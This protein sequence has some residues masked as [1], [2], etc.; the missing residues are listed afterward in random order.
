MNL[1]RLKEKI[2]A[3]QT[4]RIFLNALLDRIDRNG[5][6]P[7]TFSMPADSLTD[8]DAVRQFFSHAFTKIDRKN[9]LQVN[10][11]DYLNK[12]PG[13]VDDFYHALQRLPKNHEASKAKQI[14]ATLAAID[15]TIANISD[16]AG[17]ASFQGW[18]SA[19]REKAIQGKGELFGMSRNDNTAVLRAF[20]DKLRRGFAVLHESDQPL[21]LSHF[22]LA[23]TG[24]SKSCRTGT[25][26]YRCFAEIIGK[27]DNSVREMLELLAVDSRAEK[28][29]LVFEQTRLSFDSA[30]TQLLVFGNLVFQKN[31]RKFSYIADHAA[32]GEAVLL[33]WKQLNA[34]EILVAPS[35]VMTIEN[36]TSFYDFIERV[37]PQEFLVICTMGQANRMLIWL[38][39]QLP[40]F[41]QSFQHWGDLDRS[42]V[43]ILESLRRRSGI[44]IKAFKMDIGTYKEHLDKGLPLCAA[45]K[46]RLA[47]LLKREPR[48][49]CKDLLVEILQHLLWIEQENISI[50]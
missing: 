21:R 25:S 22:G 32:S 23:V 46:D 4:I 40:P 29:R 19:E 48:I 38:L 31:G 20:L 44:D 13:A 24:D 50:P 37:D 35:Q 15:T 41:C 2:A 8:A 27:Y 26:L 34:A 39:Q 30:A 11:K 42:G 17:F 16:Q 1:T 43:L 18:L 14:D 45:E 3:N 12:L 6:P 9:N 49:S 36:E 33:G 5:M 28:H 47:S 7:L 10:L